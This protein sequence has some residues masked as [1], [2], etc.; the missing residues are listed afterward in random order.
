MLIFITDLNNTETAWRN[1]SEINRRKH[2]LIFDPERYFPHVCSCNNIQQL[3]KSLSGVIQREWS[4]L[5]TISIF[6]VNDPHFVIRHVSV[7]FFPFSWQYS[8]IVSLT[9]LWKFL[10]FL[11]YL[12]YFPFRTIPVTTAGLLPI[13]LQKQHMVVYISLHENDSI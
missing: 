9:H 1:I 10:F 4:C 5:V 3:V 2:A 11:Q 8:Y 12:K 7:C 6:L 13:L